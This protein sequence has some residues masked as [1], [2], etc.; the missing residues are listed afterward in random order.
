M[1]KRTDGDAV[2]VV[3]PTGGYL[4]DVPVFRNG[5]HGFPQKDVAAGEKVA[6]SIDEGVYEI[7]VPSGLTLGEGATVYISNDGEDTLDDADSD[8]NVPFAKVI[9]GY[10]K[11]A[12]NVVWVKQLP[13]LAGLAGE[14][15]S[16]EYS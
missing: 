1:A 12:N 8:G 4:K 10:A 16:G 15:V 9:P 13:Q 3:A 6:L 5:F 7:E 11:D 14:E 2:D